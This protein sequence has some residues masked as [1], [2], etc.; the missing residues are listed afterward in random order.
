MIDLNENT[1][2][3]GIWYVQGDKKDYLAAVLR[4][5]DD[6][7]LKLLYRF[8]YYAGP[9]AWDGNDVKHWYEA[10]VPS[11]QSEDQ[12]VQVVERII[13]RLLTKGFA[14]QPPWRRVIKGG[15]KATMDVLKEAPFVHLREE[16]IDESA[17]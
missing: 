17:N 14:T 2:C 10:R 12:V 8:R 6:E 15:A 9:D 7:P 13:D 4:Q 3:L 16:P 1:Y 11:D 5:G